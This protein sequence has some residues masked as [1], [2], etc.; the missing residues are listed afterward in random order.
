MCL[1]MTM[2][3]EA[4]VCQVLGRISRRSSFRLNRPVVLGVADTRIQRR[5]VTCCIADH[6]R[7]KT[8]TSGGDLALENIHRLDF[9]R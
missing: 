8:V 1:P 2:P 3:Y 7:V 4:H 6:M 5:V 9:L